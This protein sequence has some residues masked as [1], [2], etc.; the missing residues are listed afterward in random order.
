MGQRIQKL[1]RQ[2]EHFEDTMHTNM[3]AAISGVYQ[4]TLSKLSFRIQVHGNSQYLQQSQVS[5]Q[6]RACL[7]AGVRAAMLWRQLG[8]R[9]WHLLFKRKSI[10]QTLHS[11]R[12]INTSRLFL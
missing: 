10:L 5:D 8:G 6:V 3:I 9:R 2:K 7:L 12:F 1:S 11:S 4:D